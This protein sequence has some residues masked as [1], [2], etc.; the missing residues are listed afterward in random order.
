LVP[1]A[2]YARM[3]T[4]HQRYSIDTQM[5]FIRGFASANAMTIAREYADPGRS[6]LTLRERPELSRLIADVVAGEVPFRAV[7]VYDVS[8]WGR[9]QDADESA[10]YECLCKRAGAPVIYCAEPFAALAGP[11]SD[12]RKALKRAMAGEF[13]RELSTRVAAGKARIG[14]LGFRIGGPAGYGL[15]RQVLEDGERP[16]LVLRSRQRKGVQT[17]RVTLVPGPPEELEVIWRN[18][19]DYLHRKRSSPQIAAALNAEGILC[20]EVRWSANH[21]ETVLSNEKYIGNSIVCKTVQRLDA[22]TKFNPPEAWIRLDGAF[23]AIVPKSDFDAAARR[24]RS[25]K[26]N[27]IPRDDLLKSLTKVLQREGRLTAAIINAAPDLPSAN[28]VEARFGSL[29]VAYGLLGYRG[30][31][32]WGH[33]AIDFQLKALADDLRDDLAQRLVALGIGVSRAKGLLQLETGQLVELR[34]ARFQR[35]KPSVRGWRVCFERGP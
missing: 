17:D 7:L 4:D 15:R 31:N 21:V 33:H 12:V 34:V 20:G 13:S 16:G 26:K 6:G 25:R 24:R 30:P 22:G 18:Y 27:F 10:H 11:F 32:R 29:S 8:R 3:S 35:P 2:A 19:A 14:G 9:F 1:V 28:T 23:E 5:A